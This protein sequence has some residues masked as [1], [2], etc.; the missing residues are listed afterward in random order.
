MSKYRMMS[1]RSRYRISPGAAAEIWVCTG[2]MGAVGGCDGCVGGDGFVRG[3][4]CVR[5]DG[6]VRGEALELDERN[7][8]RLAVLG[9]G[10]IF[11]GQSFYR[12][13]FLVL[14]RY[15]LDDEARLRAEHGLLRHETKRRNRR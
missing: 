4:R 10:E 9:D 5:G 7:L 3:D 11:G 8:L 12:P 2:A 6:C 15:R 14:H 1:R 13:P